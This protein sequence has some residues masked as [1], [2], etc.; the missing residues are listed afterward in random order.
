MYIS[1]YYIIA[2]FLHMQFHPQMATGNA[3]AFVFCCVCLL[4]LQGVS[5]YLYT[6]ATALETECSKNRSKKLRDL[7]FA[8]DT[9]NI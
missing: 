7:L 1:M 8:A 5:L 9:S 4:M 3:T 6:A 2:V